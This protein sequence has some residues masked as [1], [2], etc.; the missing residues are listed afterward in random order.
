VALA[1][2]GYLAFQVSRL[3]GADV[4][5]ATADMLAEYKR[6]RKALA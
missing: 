5:Q 3:H 6:R 2:F 1:S 4:A